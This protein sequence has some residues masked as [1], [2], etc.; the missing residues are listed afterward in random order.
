MISVSL[1]R[2]CV[3]KP[4]HRHVHG[5]CFW[6]KFDVLGRRR[7]GVNK[8]EEGTG[9]VDV[10]L[11]PRRGEEQQKGMSVLIHLTAL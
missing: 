9:A 2:V 5:A 11:R 1:G 10:R 8:G 3:G 4:M 7:G 6:C